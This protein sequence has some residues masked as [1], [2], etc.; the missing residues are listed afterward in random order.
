MQKTHKRQ[1]PLVPLPLNK[2]PMALEETD[3]TTYALEALKKC[4]NIKPVTLSQTVA[5]EEDLEGPQT[6]APFVQK[7]KDMLN[8]PAVK[9]AVWSKDGT[10]AVFYQPLLTR[11]LSKYFNKSKI[12]SFVRQLNFY[13]FKKT[14]GKRDGKWVFTHPYFTRNGTAHHK[15]RRKTAG[16]DTTVQLLRKQVGELRTSLEST[17]K[18]L[19][20]VA[21]ALALV[22]AERRIPS[23]LS[24]LDANPAKRLRVKTPRRQLLSP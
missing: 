10:S 4:A 24:P 20:D 22:L 7:L 3:A 6:L 2:I 14:Q 1:L 15:V 17:Q 5:S 9:S 11:Q 19:A 16:N 23:N 13:G 8:D 21:D 12:G 18:K